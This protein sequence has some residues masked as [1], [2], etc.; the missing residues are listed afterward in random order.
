M[1]TFS[2]TV[3]ATTI[4]DRMI[5]TIFLIL[6]ASVTSDAKFKLPKS[7]VNLLEFPLNLEYLECEFFLFGSLGRGLDQI[8]PNLT[9]GGPPPIGVRKANLSVLIKDIITQFGLQEVGHIRAIKSTIRGF[10]RPLM[11]L[12]EAAFANVMNNAFGEPLYPPFDPYANDINYLLACY[13]IPYVGLTGYVG[14]NP[15]LI[16]PV[17]KGVCF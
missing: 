13:V 5:A 10:S 9:G 16:S 7:D 6:L 12:S 1:V 17:A 2:S 4:V 15:Y 14:A 3:S 11:N 8:Q